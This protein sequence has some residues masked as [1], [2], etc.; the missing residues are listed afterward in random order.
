MSKA[1]KEMLFYS[2]WET[3]AKK[4]NNCADLTLDL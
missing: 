4:V 2:S 3:V 1:L